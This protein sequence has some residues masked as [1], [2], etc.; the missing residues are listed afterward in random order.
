MPKSVALRPRKKKTISR[1]LAMNLS[2]GLNNLVSSSLIDN[3]EF[4]EMLNIEYDEGGVARK[5]AGYTTVGTALTAAKGLGNL[6]TESVNYLCTIDGTAFKY[7]NAGVWTS[8]SGATYTSGREVVFTQVRNKIYV[9]NGS[10]GGSSWDGTTLTRPGTMPKASFGIFYS[11]RHIVSGVTGQPNRLYISATDDGSMFTRDSGAAL[12]QNSTE[13]PGATVFTDN[14][15][16]Q[17]NYI[18]VRKD[19]GDVIT[20]LGRYAN[21]LI[22]FKRRSIYQLDFDSSSNPVITP[23]TAAT[24][25]LSHKSIESVE[26]DVYFLSPEGI[27]VLGNEPQYFTAVRTNVISIKIQNTIDAINPQYANKSNAH[28]YNNKYMLAIPTT[29]SSISKVI[30]YD[31]R[32]AGFSVWDTIIPN[33]MIEY[34]DSTNTS[35][36][37]WMSDSG[38]QM[39]EIVQGRY[40]DNGAA[41]DAYVI[42][43]AQD[44]G[45]IDITKRFVDLGL[46]FR[47]LTGLISVTIYLDDDSSAGTVVLGSSGGTSGMGLGMF[48]TEM[49]GTAGE[50]GTTSASTS[51]T[52]LRVV[53]NQSSR[54]LKFK[55]SNSRVD[56]NFVFLGC[57]YGFYPRSH[58]NFDSANKIYI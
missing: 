7:L 18:D 21:T 31:K 28:Y 36:L 49:L 54:S 9:W 23:I 32:F 50:S 17:A 4:S 35:H 26:N 40:N 10:E 2:K 5:R 46:A 41:I 12:L 3:R 33:A 52:V 34:V 37:Y 55:I 22:V 13:V 38:T 43:K 57:I 48:G 8:V 19:D 27:R 53:I 51:D 6:K 39:Y 11:D 15:A 14:T 16:P 24:G 44:F 25:C 47:R 42:S 45:N 1:V 29:S 20:G 30:T 56:E 58:F